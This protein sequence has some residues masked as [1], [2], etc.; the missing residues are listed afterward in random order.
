M[1][2]LDGNALAGV[3]GDLLAG[4]PTTMRAECAGCGAESVIAELVVTLDDRGGVARCPHCTVVMLDIR[5][6]RLDVRG[7]RALRPS[8]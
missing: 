7:I 3:L 5:E 6:S 2:D 4:D 8:A 1:T